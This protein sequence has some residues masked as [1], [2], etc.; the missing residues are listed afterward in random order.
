M[1]DAVT[2]VKFMLEIVK[3]A[4]QRERGQKEDMRREVKK[5]FYLYTRTG[6]KEKPN[7]RVVS[8]KI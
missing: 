1:L 3:K 4:E 8:H 2:L 7:T 6:R 5:T